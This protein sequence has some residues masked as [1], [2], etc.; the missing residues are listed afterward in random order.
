LGVLLFGDLDP[1]RVGGGLALRSLRAWDEVLAAWTEAID[2]FEKLGDRE[3]AGHVCW[4]ASTQ[5]GWAAR[6]EEALVMV[7]RGMA[8]LEGLAHPD[9][10]RLLALAAIIFGTGGYRDAA[11]TMLADA[12]LVAGE[13]ADDVVTGT[14]M[15]ADSVIRWEYMEMQ[16]VVELDPVALETLRRSGSLW[17]L[18]ET[19]GCIVYAYWFLGRWDEVRSLAEEILPLAESL[20]NQQALFL[21]RRPVFGME[22][23][24]SGDLTAFDGANRV[25]LETCRAAALPYEAES[26]IFVGETDYLLG[27]SEHA[28]EM[29]EKAVRMEEEGT[30]MVGWHRSFRVRLLARLGMRQKA[31]AW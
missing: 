13:V 3:A 29:A 2:T 1:L 21:I 22:L 28:L 19:A 20:G 11:D 31:L 15:W 9:L 14:V 10:P 18:V 23:C 26:Y 6:W 24:Q 12:S 8:A 16:R 17:L 5:L 25:D 4:E 7:G 30:I 27:R